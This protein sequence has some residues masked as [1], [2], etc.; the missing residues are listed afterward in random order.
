MARYFSSVSHIRVPPLLAGK[1]FSSVSDPFPESY[2]F[3]G[4]PA[5]PLLPQLLAVQHFIKPTRRWW[6]ECLQDMTQ[7]YEYQYPSRVYSQLCL[8]RNQ[9][10][11]NKNDHLY[12]VHK[13]IPPTHTHTHKQ[14]LMVLVALQARVSCFVW[15]SPVTYDAVPFT[16]PRCKP[17]FL[18]ESLSITSTTLSLP[19]QHYHAE[20]QPFIGKFTFSE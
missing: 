17:S 6:G 20:L 1:C 10:L 5:F 18:V 7:P 8:H 16:S 4:T 9:H 3:P 12:M 11:N 2:L 14:L 15:N 19:T 13:K